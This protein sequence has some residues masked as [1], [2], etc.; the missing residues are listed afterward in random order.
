MIEDSKSRFSETAEKILRDS[1]RIASTM[2][3]G[4]GSEHLL[5]ALSSNPGTV[6]YEALRELMV[7]PERIAFILPGLVGKLK[8]ESGVSSEIKQIL[9][10]AYQKAAGFGS[11]SVDSEHL[12]LALVANKNYNGHTVL[13]ELGVD[14]KLLKDQLEGYLEQIASADQT[15]MH[16]FNESADQSDQ[17][18]SP[19]PGESSPRAPS[20]AKNAL[21]YFTTDLTKAA[22]VGKLD[23][24]IG[25]TAEIQRVC[26]I[27]VRRTKNNPVLTGEPGVGKTA[28][29]EGLATK[30]AAGDVPSQLADKRLLSLDLA[31]LIAGTTYRGQFEERTKKLL[32]EIIKAGNV[33]LFLDEIHTIVGAGAAEGSM[34]LGH[35]LKPALAKGAL[36]LIG[37][38]TNEEYRKYIEKDPA[39]E[40]RLQ[41]INV[42]EPS[43][44][45]TIE[46]LRGLKPVYESHHALTISDEA[47]V[48]ATELAKRYINDRYLPDKAIDLI[49]EA[50][51]ATHLE[52]RGLKLHNRVGELETK[53]RQA[54]REHQ[55]AAEEFNYRKSAAWRVQELRL[56]NEL[57]KLKKTLPKEKPTRVIEREDIARVVAQWTGIPVTALSKLEKVRL[58]NLEKVLK[59]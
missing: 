22:K 24:V 16:R 39:L 10:I 48:T 1:E 35:I 46:I 31:L 56:I 50:A 47:V 18:V 14:P 12:L 2:A 7:T 52:P 30:I 55:R 41:R 27:L 19:F 53:R 43:S 15:V 6:A 32:D 17:L 5:V 58:T 34:D 45:E 25:R 8:T 49:D 26:Q 40:R 9:K 57:E 33:I 20:R 36:R 37:A 4:I 13:L 59:D 28:I 38:T 21:D 3:T 23:P 42:E 54:N 29:V 11:F 51:A 44:E